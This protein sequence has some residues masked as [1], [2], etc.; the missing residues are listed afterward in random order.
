MNHPGDN[1]KNGQQNIHPEM[2][3]DPD[4]K[5]SSHRRQDNG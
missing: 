2:D 3:P 1:S 5:K 4:L